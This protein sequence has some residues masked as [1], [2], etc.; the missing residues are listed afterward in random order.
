MSF[1]NLKSGL[2]S[3]GEK[4]HLETDNLILL[5]VTKEIESQ[6]DVIRRMSHERNFYSTNF[7]SQ[8]TV[9]EHST[10][11]YLRAGAISDDSRILFLIRDKQGMLMGQV[12]FKNLKGA[13]TELDAVMKYRNSYF[14][15]YRVIQFLLDEIRV[16]LQIKFVSLE[17]RSDNKK[18]ILLYE[19]LGFSLEQ[20]DSREMKCVMGLTFQ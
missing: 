5:P 11:T 20:Q 14:S 1:K 13:S 16:Q 3:D 9:T 4:L 10:L 2:N 15:M 18:A 19:K 17:V 7:F 6:K 12:G 8:T